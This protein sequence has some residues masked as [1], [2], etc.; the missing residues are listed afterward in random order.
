MSL[1]NRFQIAVP[2][3]SRRVSIIATAFYL[4][5][6]GSSIEDSIE[7]LGGAPDVQAAAKHELVLASTR[8]VEP[9]IQAL[10]SDR[11]TKIRAEVADILVSLTMR[12][13]DERIAAVLEKHLLSDPEPVVRG[14]I[15]EE[16]GF[17]LRSEF[18]DPLLRAISDPSPLVQ[19]P[20]L[21]SFSNAMGKLSDEQTQTLRR[22]AGERALSEDKEVREAALL[23]VEEYVARSAEKARE[24]AL[25][26]NLS[27]ADSLF[28]A[29]VAYAPNS[30]QARYYQGT[31]HLDYLERDRG[32]EILRGHRLLVD[33]PRLESTPTID[34]RLDDEAWEDAALID[35]F[36]VHTRRGRTTL[37]PRVET[38]LL[39]GY[40]AKALYWG[41]HCADA[42]PESLVVLQHE[43]G[44]YLRQDRFYL[45]FD[46]NRDTKTIS[47][48]LVNSQ[49]AT[50]DMRTS[51]GRD[52]DFKWDAEVTTATYVGEDFWSLECELRWDPV[53]HPPPES[54]ELSRV[55]FIRL[56]RTVEFSQSFA[57]YDNLIASGFL[58][59]E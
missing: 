23:L 55:N 39:L 33:V 53:Y 44:A 42:H 49:G 52:A 1:Q 32:I 59:Y 8:A 10:A 13:A 35:S 5:A 27:K 7:G 4:V 31:F 48:I 37:P 18:F 26:A 38:R 34:G 15:A 25:K 12:T 51:K 11:K 14:R 50:V 16:L 46:R 22:L 41:A 40:S 45:R 57:E 28:A 19:A 58:L 9:L 20:A 3:R 54:G 21:L 43:D 24:A 47:R 36:Y 30:K 6:C 56:F 29:L 2:I 17:H